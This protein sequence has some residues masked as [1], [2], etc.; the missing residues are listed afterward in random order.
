MYELRFNDGRPTETFDNWWKGARRCQELFP[1]CW[2]H[3]N[4]L[5]TTDEDGAT[6]PLASLQPTL[7]WQEAGAL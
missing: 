2:M 5:I 4:G 6:P 3:N 7:Y 1:D